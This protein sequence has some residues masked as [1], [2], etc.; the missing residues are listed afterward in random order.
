MALTSWSAANY[1]QRLSA[2]YDTYPF[3]ISVWV[4]QPT[5][6]AAYAVSI[7]QQATSDHVRGQ[8]IVE[9]ANAFLAL[10]RSTASVFAA[11]TTTLATNTWS[12]GFGEFIATNS[13]AASVN[14]ANRGTNTGSISPNAS[15]SL[16]I[17]RRQGAT[18]SP[19]PAAAAI[20]EV[21]IW[22]GTGMSDA[23]RAS[24]HSKLYNGGAGGAGG[25]PININAEV[26]QPWTAKLEAYYI[27]SANAITD[28][29]GNGHDLTMVGT[30][31]NFGSHPNI[32]AV[33]T[34]GLLGKLAGQG[35]LVGQRKGLVA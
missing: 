28:L 27:N 3:I 35:G 7:G 9:S 22:D 15:D 26:G 5:I 20:A 10:T 21:S 16:F 8:M 13:R 32:E 23:N 29:S 24:L 18:D 25:N 33:A 17:G 19:F 31:T 14:G 4:N 2:V 12:L 6:T 1:L 11:S 30:L 34:G